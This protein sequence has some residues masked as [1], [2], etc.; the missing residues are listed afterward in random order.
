[1]DRIIEVNERLAY[2]VVEP[3][4]TQGQ[5]ADHLRQNKIRL[6]LDATGAGTGASLVGNAVDRGFG[7]TR[8]GDHV[9][10]SCSLQVVLADGRVLNTGF[11]H[12]EN[13][14]AQYVYR[15]GVGPSLDGLFAQS[16]LGVVT[17][18][19]LW[20]MPEPEAFTAFFIFAPGD[21]DVGELIDR[22]SALRMSGLLQSTVH[23]GNDLR[24]MAAR[25]RYPFDRAGG[26]TPLPREVRMQMRREWGISAWSASGA[27]YGTRETVA[28]SRR[29]LRRGMGQ[30]KVVFVDDRKLALARRLAAA[31]PWTPIGKRLR[32]TLQSLEAPYG[33][34]KGVPSEDALRGAAW[35]V[36]EAD[37]QGSLDPLDTH[38]GLMWVS[39]ILPATAEHVREVMGIIEPIYESH[40]FE[41]LVTFTMI[42]ERAL[43]CVSNLSFDRRD[44]AELAR[45]AAC[46][47][48]LTDAL[49]RRG[50]IPYRTSPKTAGKLRQGS[51]VFWDVAA[52]IKST[53]DP[54]GIISPGRY[55]P[56]K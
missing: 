47:E 18:I 32:A 4:V 38:A 48:A 44:A 2:A 31:F 30:F 23:V 26:R 17:R 10:S 36:R 11:G 24:V 53:L 27:L 15:Y 9:L 40:G 41:T 45:A 42:T 16:N 55:E 14:K 28:A 12:Y 20:L 46:H 37:L 34:L 39:P 19:G 52:A 1:M 5:L 3:G 51:S 6:W 54:A 33:L 56:L 35:R 7:H 50:Y 43:C 22:L 13:A 8:L 29:A 21:D 25:A 49:M